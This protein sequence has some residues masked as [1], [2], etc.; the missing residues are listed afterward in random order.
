MLT[1]K[2]TEGTNLT[3]HKNKSK[4]FQKFEFYFFREVDLS[5]NLFTILD[6][7]TIDNLSEDEK[8]IA[9]KMLI[10][11]L[12]EKID[13]RWLFGLEEIGSGTAYEFLWEMFEKEENAYDKC[14]LAFSLV[15]I[16]AGSQ[17]LDY[18]FEV[19]KSDENEQVKERALSPLYWNKDIR[20]ESKNYNELFQTILHTAIA[21]KYIKIRLYAYEILIEYHDMDDFIPIK[22]HFKIA[23]SE[24]KSKK[25]Y[26]EILKRFLELVESKQEH[27]VS[28]KLIIQAIKELPNNPS[29]L[30]ISD[31][32]I[33]SKIPE[34][35]Y[36]D[37]AEDKS[38]ENYT[39]KLERVIIFAYYKDCIMRCP[40][41][42]RLYIYDYHYEYLVNKSEEEEELI[43][44]DTKGAISL[45]DRFIKSSYEFKKITKCGIFL[46]VSYR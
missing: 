36:A 4:E 38:L 41:C 42:G 12:E 18:L 39:S 28:R 43:R 35:S 17:V 29:T 3:S 24:T 5:K 21:D 6:P 10:E 16:N 37:M 11:A 26:K 33:C 32:E 25:E 45:V 34:K 15:K 31:C 46:K 19:I 44:T 20:Y 30:K 9:E 27:P 13:K 2:F 22:D 1:D 40:I 8:K 7:S 14:Q 23:F